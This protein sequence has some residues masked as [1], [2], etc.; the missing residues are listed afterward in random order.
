MEGP[1]YLAV[2]IQPGWNTDETVFHQWYNTEHGP[3]RL[4]LPFI[5]TGDRY[6]AIDEQKPAWSAVYDVTDLAWLQKRIYT[7]LREERSLREKAVMSTFESLDRKIYSLVSVRG[8]FSG[9]PPV[10]RAVSLKVNES[11]LDEFNKW[12]EEE[13]IDMLSKV[14]GWLR[15]RRFLM[16][17]GGIQGMPPSGQI[18]IL[19]VH[20]FSKSDALDGPEWK[21]A[22]STQWRNKMI[23]KVLWRDSRTWSHY[24]SFDALEEPASSVITTDDAELRFQL[25]GNPADPVIVCV[26]S[27][28]TNLH[29]WDDFTKALIAGV[30]GNTYRVLRYNSRGYSQQSEKSNHTSFDILAD[31]LEYLLQRVNV[32]KVHAVVGVSMGGVTAINFAIRHPDMLEK[33]VACDCNVAS[34]PANSQAWAGRVQLAKTNGISELAKITVARWFTPE[35]H[36]SANAKKVL[37]MA[38]QAN[39]EGFEQNTL[40]L[41]NYDLR[42]RLADITSPGLLIA[43]EGDGKIPEAMQKFGIA[44]TTFKSI[45]KAGHLPFLENHDAFVQAVAQF[46]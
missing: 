21:A 25:E 34:S 45:P 13:H 23:E 43:G 11:D 41:S 17:I 7:R 2:V 5:Q 38:E 24:L 1:G 20:D 36:D 14:P 30:N 44:N 39:L 35:N 31:D 42:P 32:E 16:R 3:L 27:I 26:N 6:K 29:I 33:Y 40:A 19:A 46:L 9:P 4:R 37:P 8:E 10:T 15:T 12:Y 28:M 18:E 22:T